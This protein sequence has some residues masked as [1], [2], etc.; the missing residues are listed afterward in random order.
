MEGE[1]AYSAFKKDMENK[2]GLDYAKDV[3]ISML[4]GYGDFNIGIFVINI[5]NHGK[6]GRYWYPCD[7]CRGKSDGRVYY[8]E[9]HKKEKIPMGN[10]K[11][12]RLFSHIILFV[13][14]VRAGSGKIRKGFDHH[15]SYLCR[16]RYSGRNDFL[17]LR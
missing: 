15:A 11:W 17:V 6:Y 13:Q 7:L 1:S 9:T 10:G 4:G 14:D 2:K 12:N 16:K 3:L 8:W 5:T